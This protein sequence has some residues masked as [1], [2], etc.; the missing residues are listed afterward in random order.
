VQALHHQHRVKENANG[1]HDVMIH[2]FGSWTM[3]QEGW[4]EERFITCEA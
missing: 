4:G 1:T 2:A 3:A